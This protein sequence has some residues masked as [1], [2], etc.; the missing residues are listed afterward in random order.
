VLARDAWGQGYATEALIAMRDLALRLGV[1]RLYALCHPEHTAS[2]RVLEK[3]GFVRE[4]LMRG[5]AEFPNLEPGRK[6]DVLCYST[7]FSR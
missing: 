1:D 2:W 6:S 3:G 4:G 5:Y 7:V